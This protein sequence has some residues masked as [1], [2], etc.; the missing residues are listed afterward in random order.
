[1]A[2]PQK[3]FNKIQILTSLR[4]SPKGM[5]TGEFKSIIGCTRNTARTILV[6]LKQE[7]LVSETGVQTI[8]RGQ[9]ITHIKAGV[10][11]NRNT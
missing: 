5:S 9:S 11:N 1:M 4:S 6:K 8:V 7:G 10:T 2:Q 3:K